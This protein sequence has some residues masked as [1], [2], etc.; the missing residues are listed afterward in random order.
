MRIFPSLNT[1]FFFLSFFLFF[2]LTCFVNFSF[3]CSILSFFLCFFFVSL[4]FYFLFFFFSLLAFLFFLISITLLETY[5]DL[6]QHTIAA[7]FIPRKGFTLH[8]QDQVCRVQ[9]RLLQTLLH[10]KEWLFA[11]TTTPYSELIIAKMCRKFS[12]CH[13]IFDAAKIS[14]P[15][16]F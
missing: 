6:F 4:F 3:F 13:S 1:I 10:V 2:F 7:L 12:F 14:S 9:T 5:N 15:K 11:T 8:F 16:H